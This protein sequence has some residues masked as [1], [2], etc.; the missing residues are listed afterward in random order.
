[1]YGS[2]NIL[3]ILSLFK[4]Q[5]SHKFA[6]FSY[7]GLRKV[8]TSAKVMISGQKCPMDSPPTYLTSRKPNLYRGT[9]DIQLLRI[10]KERLL[11]YITLEP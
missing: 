10:M 5:K 6:N 3:F 9:K 2:K 4:K 11:T 1:M 8:L 7:P